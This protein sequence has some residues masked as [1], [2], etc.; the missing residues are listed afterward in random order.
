MRHPPKCTGMKPQPYKNIVV[1]LKPP[2][3]PTP[4]R[5]TVHMSV[6]NFHKK[7]ATRGRKTGYRKTT[8]AEDKAIMTAFFK[9][10]RPCGAAVGYKDVWCA[11]ADGLRCKI[12]VKTVKR[13]LVEKGFNLEDKLTADDKGT[14]WRRRRLT[15]C[16]VH[17]G[18]SED[19]WLNAV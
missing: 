12:S 16:S 1:A 6:K 10:R 8:P 13:R 18:K 17:K 15:F 5:T 19:Q 14:A 3:Q 11:L 9:A 2:G 4:K 7:A